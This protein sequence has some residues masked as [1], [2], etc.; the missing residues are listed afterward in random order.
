MTKIKNQIFHADLWGIRQQKYHV[1]LEADLKSMRWKALKPAKPFYLFVPQS[2]ELRE[3]YEQGWK[4]TE[5][6]PV[7]SVGIVTARDSLTIHFT[8]NELWRTVRDFVALPVEAARQKYNLGKDARDWKITLA[9]K[10]LQESHLSENH[11]TPIVYRPFDVRRTYYTGHSRGFHCMPRGEVM[12]HMLPGENIGII[13]TRLTK[14]EWS[15]LATDNIIAHKSGSRYDISYLFPLYLYPPTEGQKKPKID[16]FEEDDPFQGK[17][18]IENFAPAFR[19]EIDATYGQHYCPEDVLGYIYA[20]L[21]S[22]TYRAKY[23]EFLKIDFPRIPFVEDRK[24][25]EILS[26]LGQELV[27]AHLL[28]M[29]PTEPKVSVTKGSFEVEKPTYDEKHQRLYINKDQYFSPVSKEVWEFRI[30]GY[31]VLDK[32]LKSRKDRTLSLD[33][34]ENI[35]HVVKSLAFTIQQMQKIDEVWKSSAAVLET[36]A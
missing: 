18:R 4:V 36:V 30:G 2:E 5:I 28:K 10:D 35:Q 31:Q 22:P 27:Q 29:I 24:T 32:Y 20:V 15:A 13:T 14:D 8:E 26:E 23:L 16:L 21:H 19:K 9:Q 34:I 1:L 25:F 6:F 11:S 3:E 12:R 17:E 7:S 33:E